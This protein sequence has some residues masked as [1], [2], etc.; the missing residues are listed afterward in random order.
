MKEWVSV[1]SK[2]AAT[3][4]FV[5]RYARIDPTFTGY[6]A[7]SLGDGQKPI[8]VEHSKNATIGPR[9]SNGVKIGNGILVMVVDWM[10]TTDSVV[11]G[12][13]TLEEMGY[14]LAVPEYVTLRTTEGR[15]CCPRNEIGSRNPTYSAAEVIP[16]M[17]KM[18]NQK[19]K[20]TSK[21]GFS[22][23]TMAAIITTSSPDC[24]AGEA[25]ITASNPDNKAGEA[26][27]DVTKLTPPVPTESE[28]SV[29]SFAKRTLPGPT[30]EQD[31]GPVTGTDN[32]YSMLEQDLEQPDVAET[33]GF[34]F[35]RWES[36]YVTM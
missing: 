5:L 27:I 22:F 6:L 17:N 4:K 36:N 13:G 14:S 30:E 32:P 20:N 28:P 9:V 29:S 21:T 24:Q 31:S 35:Q 7:S 25:T 12:H 26:T 33:G 1:G 3:E 15:L 23:G 8:F 10:H 2:K 18:D 11:L 16:P 34:K 19:P